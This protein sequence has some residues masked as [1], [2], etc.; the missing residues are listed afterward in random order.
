MTA[1]T[2]GPAV[3][4]LLVFRR[5]ALRAARVGHV[6]ADAAH[7]ADVALEVCGA[8]TDAHSGLRDGAE[9]LR[10]LGKDA[11]L[12]QSGGGHVVALV[13]VALDTPLLRVPGVRETAVRGG[14]QVF[15]ASGAT[16]GGDL[17]GDRHG[18]AGLAGEVHLQL[19]ERD[20]LV[21]EVTDRT[22]LNVAVDAPAIF[23]RPLRP[24]VVVGRHLVA[25][26]AELR[27][28]RQHGH[29]HNGDSHEKR[30]QN[31]YRRMK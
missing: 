20:E 25:R 15:V 30:Q 14:G 11:G 13:G 28:V 26:R 31:Q 22:G 23:V 16:L 24:S 7:D 8:T 29:A 1:L 17:R 5:V 10:P 4:C 9:Q 2:V 3:G 19:L 21:H 6:V 27:A 18:E 12:S